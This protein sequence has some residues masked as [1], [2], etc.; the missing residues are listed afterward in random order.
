MDHEVAV[1]GGGVVG[2]AVALELARRGADVAL[3]EALPE[4]A[5]EASG[6]NSGVLHT[7][8]DSV[9]GELETELILRAAR[10][11]PAVLEALAVPVLRCGAQMRPLDA[12]DEAAVAA[13]AA[14]ARANGVEASLRDDGA[15]EVPG[16]SVTDP[17][18]FTL[19]LVAAAE[20]HGARVR[21]GFRVEAIDRARGRLSL[22]GEGDT[23]SAAFAVNCAGNGA[24][25]VARMAGDDSF[26]VYPRKGEFLVFEPPPG[27][28]LDRI[29]L[30]V[31]T[32]RTKGVLVFPTLDGK[33]VAGPTAV[34]LEAA[35]WSVRPVAREEILP[36]ASRMHPPLSD[37]EPMFAYAGLRPAGRGVNYVI[38]SSAAEPAL[39]NVAAIRSTGL[40]ASLA[41][42]EHVAGLVAKAGAS[43]GEPEPLS[44]GPTSAEVRGPWWRRT[45]DRVGR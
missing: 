3:L 33:V 14:N 24:G 12:G 34:D 26:D 30:P 6:T 38:A 31:P 19:A 28:E 8:F 45:A 18:A 36:K 9:P 7:G 10:L 1:I 5:L 41:I 17:V 40:T 13:L 43:L 39:V 23:V 37:A 27:A 21:T 2:A 4:P 16:E 25:A 11:R 44:P 22:R 42:A 20:R 35:D 15:L 32:T 29:L